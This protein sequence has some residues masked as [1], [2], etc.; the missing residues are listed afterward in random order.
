LVSIA[1][2]PVFIL[3]LKSLSAGESLA[4]Y[5]FFAPVLPFASRRGDPNERKPPPEQRA[6]ARDV[7]G[8]NKEFISKAD[9]SGIFMLLIYAD[10][11][12]LIDH[13]ICLSPLP[14]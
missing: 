8:I 10:K 13:Q 6:A 11:V 2:P 5:H 7:A 1:R 4:Y 12:N 3:Y 14:V 9:C